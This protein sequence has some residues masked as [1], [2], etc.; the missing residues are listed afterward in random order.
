MAKTTANDLVMGKFDLFMRATNHG[1][2]LK[3][4]LL[5]KVN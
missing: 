2:T 4:I 5:K 3:F 1:A